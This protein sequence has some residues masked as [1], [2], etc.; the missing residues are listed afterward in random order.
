VGVTLGIYLGRRGFSPEVIGT[1]V[2]FGL[3]GA[4]AAALVATLFADRIGRRSFLFVLSLFVGFGTLAFALLDHPAALAAA[5]FVG[6]LNGMGRDRGAALILE[7][8]ALPA[9]TDDR[10]RTAVIAGHTLLQDVGHALGALLSGAPAW[11][12]A[13]GELP[14]A[15]SQRYVLFACAAVGV[16]SA[17]LYSAVGGVIEHGRARDRLPRLSPESRPI[18]TKLS[19]L[20]T[21]DALGGGF[22]TSAL[23]SYFFFTRFQASEL[24]I[25][26]LFFG[27]RVM[28]AVSHLGAAWLAKRI[29]LINTMV[30]THIPSSLLLIT[31]AFAPTFPVAAV[32][33]LLREGLVEMDVPT[34]QSYV[35]AVVRPE[36]R[37]LATG[38]TSLVRLASWAV[39]PAI[40][41]LL[42][43]GDSYAVPLVAGAAL[44]ILYDLLLYK[45][46]RRTLPPEERAA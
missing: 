15:D 28:N 2:S 24:W 38:V 14:T 23:L 21:L 20:F 3:A 32:L 31:V 26:A 22:L 36:E 42:T 17:A 33:F 25:S 29:G 6:M 13:R 4:V 18:I 45:A 10:N 46:F 19:A 40:A 8:A 41:G 34:R 27:A 39:A 37:T 9:T 43:I 1:I 16:V 7:Q 5:A 12:V 35:L 30:F 11:F 44:K